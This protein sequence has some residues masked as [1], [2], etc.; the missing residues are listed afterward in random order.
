[1]AR[2]QTE[3]LTKYYAGARGEAICAIGDLNLEVNESELLVLVGPS[4]SG[5]TTVLRLIAGLEQP[6]SGKILIDDQLANGVLPSQRDVAMVFQSPALYPHLTVYQNMA[7]GLQIRG[8]G[9]TEIEKRVGEIADLLTLGGYLERLPMTLSGGQRQLVSLGRALVRRPR[10]LLLDEPLSHLDAPARE[11]MRGEIVRMHQKLGATMIY[12]THDQGEAMA[13][14]DRIAVISHG[15][16]QQVETPLTV[17]DRPAN[18]FVAKFMGS[19]PMNLVQGVIRN[20]GKKLAFT[21]LPGMKGPGLEA[22]GARSSSSAME[23]ELE[24]GTAA[25]VGAWLE[26]PVLLGFRPEH[27]TALTMEGGTRAG[28]MAV[29]VLVQRLGA[30]TLLTLATAVHQFV[31]RIPATEP[32]QVG[33]RIAVRLGMRHARFFDPET[34]KSII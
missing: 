21:E 18:V 12:V 19:P 28:I 14:G 31:A 3:Y 13:V 33:Q 22:S 10:L 1:V 17:Y 9:K 20:C 29:V 16:L 7:F 11:Q 34:G 24:A 26:K 4:G 6:T 5:K 15:V 25:R 2:V 32:V 8:C 23:V 30:E 27:V